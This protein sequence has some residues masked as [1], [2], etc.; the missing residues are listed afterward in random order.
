MQQKHMRK[1]G[2]PSDR[3][4]Q[5]ADAC[6]NAAQDPA[7]HTILPFAAQRAGGFY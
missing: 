6:G 5:R 3:L 2:A 4:R 7:T 1:A